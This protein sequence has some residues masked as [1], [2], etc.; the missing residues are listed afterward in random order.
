MQ[1]ETYTPRQRVKAALAHQK[2]DR[3][4]VDFLATTDVWNKM[5]G[6]FQPSVEGIEGD[7]YFDLRREAILRLLDVDC[8]LLSYDMFC[9]PPE[10]LL[11]NG[12]VQTWWDS[13]NRSTPNRMWRKR[14]ADG[15]WNDIWGTHSQRT[16]AMFGAYE[17][18]VDWPLSHVTSVDELRSF[19][20]AQP[21][22]WDFS[23]LP[24]L[25][26]ILDSHQETHIRFRIGSIF[27]IGWQLRGLEEFMMDLASQPEIPL[28][29]MDRLTET[30]LENTR[31][32]LEL[33]GDR[34]DM[35]Y[36][37]DDVATQSSLFI[38][39]KMWRNYI[40][41]RHIKFI[42]LAHSYGKPVMYHCDGAV[43]PLIHEF[44][45]MGVDLLNPVQPDASGM[46]LE[47]IKQEFGGKL[48]FHGGIDINKTLPRGTPDEVRAEVR[49]RIDVLGRG[50]GYIMCSSHHLQ[51]D[52]PLENVLAMYDTSLRAQ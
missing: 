24:S 28:Y 3:V 6:H 32:V 17:G 11:A 16:E 52:T 42:E 7:E 19:N 36:F 49:E 34:L 5:I 14:N 33:A 51:P 2:A 44:I 8:R 21:D 18:F 37:Y 48:A 12:A 23:P 45:D 50:G 46:D 10:S 22:W 4:P 40:R 38:S 1:S 20:W 39:S 15:T 47:R 27:E 13:L 9:N 30:I 29:I 41:P 25:L 43:F 35:I 31:R 26:N